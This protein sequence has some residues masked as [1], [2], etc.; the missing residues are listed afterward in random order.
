MTEDSIDTLPH[1]GFRRF[2]PSAALA[3]FVDSYWLIQTARSSVEHQELMHPGGG[4]GIVFNYGDALSFDEGPHE[5][6]C[7]FDGINT[8]TRV[9][10]LSGA[11][12]VMGIRF[13][14]AGVYALL[15]ISLSEIKNTTAS[16]YEAA[17]QLARLYDRLGECKTLR[18]K[19]LA[20]E[21]RLLQCLCSRSAHSATAVAA[22]EAI[23]SSG[24]RRPLGEISH[25]LALGRRKIER[26]F[27]EH[28]GMTPKEYA[29]SLRIATARDYL[30]KSDKS[31][32]EIALALDF[33][34]QSHFIKQ[35]KAVVGMTPQVYRSRRAALNPTQEPQHRLAVKN[36]NFE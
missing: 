24:G 29:N 31:L 20:V 1:L 13:K 12:E 16:V 11:V 9:L 26:V 28:V 10:S 7:C 30:K 32:A 36:N 25:G 34:D 18:E 8:K 5:G 2:S 14:P 3:A 22:V 23:R 19:L 33:F 15:D 27:K 4:F 21:R 17:P 35:F 6:R